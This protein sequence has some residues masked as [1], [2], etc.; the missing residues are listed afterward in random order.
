M[1][2]YHYLRYVCRCDYSG[3]APLVISKFIVVVALLLEIVEEF[4]GILEFLEKS[5]PVV[6]SVPKI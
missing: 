6:I 1:G 5:V 3:D 4:C 2:V